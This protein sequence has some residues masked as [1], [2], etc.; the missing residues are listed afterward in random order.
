ME[1]HPDALFESDQ[2]EKVLL[3]N[4][5]SELSETE[6]SDLAKESILVNEEQEKIQTLTSLPMLNLNTTIPIISMGNSKGHL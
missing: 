6:V 2:R 4:I 5:F 1:T 3:K